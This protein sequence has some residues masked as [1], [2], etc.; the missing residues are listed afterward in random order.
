MQL[1]YPIAPGASRPVAVVTGVSRRQGIGASITRHL[2]AAGVAV[3]ATGYRPFDATVQTGLDADAPDQIMSDIASAGGTAVWIE[4]DLSDPAALGSLFDTAEREAGKV[5]ILVNNAAYSVRD[6]W[7]AVTPELLDAH[8]RINVRA[9]ALL[10]VELAKRWP[11]GEGGR[12]INL[13]SGQFKGPMLGEIAYT[14][15]K[16]A[17][18]AMTI[19]MAAELGP[20]GITVNAV[21][22]GPTDTGWMTDQLKAELLPKHPLGRLGMPDDIARLILFLASEQAAWVTGQIIH[23]EGGFLRR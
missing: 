4:S 7:Q 20:L 16:G 12:V 21:G 13:T 11:G 22:P 2:A 23:T 14:S 5:S 18:D 10:T 15:S 3:L 1:T 9:T 19:T 8:Y 6:G 17:V